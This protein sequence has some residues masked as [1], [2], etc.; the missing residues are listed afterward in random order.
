MVKTH[1]IEIFAKAPFQ[2]DG[3]RHRQQAIDHHTLSFFRFPRRTE[4]RSIWKSHL[5]NY[6]PIWSFARPKPNKYL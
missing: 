3:I 6:A 1:H 5:P 4:K 2:I